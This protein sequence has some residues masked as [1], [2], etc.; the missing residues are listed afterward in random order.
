LRFLF[1]TLSP[2]A[3]LFAFSPSDV[4]AFVHVLFLFF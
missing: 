2:S 3:Q 1:Q 4:T